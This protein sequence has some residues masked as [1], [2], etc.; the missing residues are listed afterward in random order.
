MK[1]YLSTEV[2][3][4]FVEKNL[5]KLVEK[6]VARKSDATAEAIIKLA[7]KKPII[8]ENTLP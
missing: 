2:V 3:L 7:L 8:V 1:R 6:M 5:L 4:G